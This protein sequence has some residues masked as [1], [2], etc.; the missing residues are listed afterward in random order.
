MPKR[1][2]VPRMIGVV[3]GLNVCLLGRPFW[4]FLLRCDGDGAVEGSTQ[5]QTNHHVTHRLTQIITEIA[6]PFAVWAIICV[7]WLIM[8]WYNSWSR[9][10]V[11]VTGP[12]P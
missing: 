5:D 2:S 11:G 12:C 6:V 7:M 10:C 8:R 4:L 9:R 1:K 3:G